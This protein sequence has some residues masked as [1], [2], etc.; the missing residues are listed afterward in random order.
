MARLR[1]P[2]NFSRSHVMRKNI[3]W[4]SMG[5]DAD[6]AGRCIGWLL[7]PVPACLRFAYLP[8]P[9]PQDEQPHFHD[10]GPVC[11]L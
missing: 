7:P 4:I 2:T 11:H 8:E 5:G 3:L 9:M 10:P 6:H 1:M